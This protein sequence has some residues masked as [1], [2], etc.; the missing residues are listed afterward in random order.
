[1]A[2]S[3]PS[4]AELARWRN[5]GYQNHQIYGADPVSFSTGN[6][7]ESFPL[8]ALSGPGAQAIEATL[9][10]NAQDGRLSRVGA[11]WSFSLGA[12]A[13]ASSRRVPC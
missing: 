12:R 6:L 4:Q 9:V 7:V 1:M 5:L 10:Y 11:G 2:F 3:P 13:H 8:F